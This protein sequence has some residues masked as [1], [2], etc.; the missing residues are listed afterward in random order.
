V[1]YSFDQAHLE[2][3]EKNRWLTDRERVVFDLYYRRGWHIEDVAAEIDRNRRTVNRTLRSI[4][5]KS[6]RQYLS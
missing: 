1:K 3:V 5:D 6:K 2:D 4:R